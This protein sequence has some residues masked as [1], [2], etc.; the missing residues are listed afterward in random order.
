MLH[1]LQ[2]RTS[3]ICLNVLKIQLLISHTRFIVKQQ[4]IIETMNVATTERL[5]FVTLG[6]CSSNQHESYF[7]FNFYSCN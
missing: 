7:P 2:K 4:T 3:N 6:S 1:I 5:T